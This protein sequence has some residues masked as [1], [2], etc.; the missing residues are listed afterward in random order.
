QKADQEA[1]EKAQQALKK[2][3][4]ATSTANTTGTADGA[5]PETSNIGSKACTPLEDLIEAAKQQ[6]EKM[7]GE[8]MRQL[9]ASKSSK[10]AATS[11]QA[12]AV[13]TTAQVKVAAP[14]K[15]DGP[16]VSEPTTW[17]ISGST[18]GGGPASAQR[19]VS[20]D[21]VDTQVVIILK[22]LAEQSGANIVTAPTVQGTISVTLRNVTVQSALDLITKLAGVRYAFVDGTYIVGSPEFMRSMLIQDTGTASRNGTVMRV[23]PLA[24]R[25]AGEIKRAITQAMTM[26]VLNETI[27]IINPAAPVEQQPA[28]ANGQN[29]NQSG[30][31]TMEGDAD[32]LILIGEPGRVEQASLLITQL[33]RGLAGIHG[34]TEVGAD[35]LRPVS[36]AYRVQ[37]GRAAELAAAVEKFATGV[38]VVAS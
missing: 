11:P 1:F 35:A 4:P 3:T 37:G 24:S 21:F 27:Q 17:T 12:D 38:S 6:D 13:T 36:K 19:R 32:Y 28:A 20:L 25:K 18:L 9:R 10:S 14:T 34:I 22:A 2:G 5:T 7:F 16:K 26:D 31:P 23:V 29:G 30:A 8:A 33:D 15:V